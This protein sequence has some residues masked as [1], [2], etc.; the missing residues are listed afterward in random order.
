[1]LRLHSSP[2]FDLDSPDSMHELEER[3]KPALKGVR[4]DNQR[5]RFFAATLR[6]FQR[7]IDSYP[8]EQHDVDD[9]KAELNRIW[10]RAKDD[11][12]SRDSRS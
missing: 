2:I 6:E 7:I 10:E 12:E 1:M 8:V 9:F 4:E 5:N 11:G 3:L